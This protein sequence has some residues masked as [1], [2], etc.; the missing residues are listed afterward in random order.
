MI[1]I[2]ET[3]AANL[4]R[5]ME[6]KGRSL[7]ELAAAIDNPLAEA[8]LRYTGAPALTLDELNIV[9]L[10]LDIPHADLV[11]EQSNSGPTPMTAI[12]R[13]IWCEAKIL[14]RIEGI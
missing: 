5:Y 6:D 7:A 11:A 13:D 3:V 1:D 2:N 8:L 9:A 14:N 4:R 10:W 12:E